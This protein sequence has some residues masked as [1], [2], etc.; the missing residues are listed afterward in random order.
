MRAR[1]ASTTSTGDNLLAAIS[2]A[3]TDAGRR[4]GSVAIRLT[5]FISLH[6]NEGQIDEPG[7]RRD[8]AL[9]PSDSSRG[10]EI[11]EDIEPGRLVQPLVRLAI[12][13]RNHFRIGALGDR[14]QGYLDAIGRVVPNAVP[15]R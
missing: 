13:F 15:R 5:S 6:A 8:E 11:V 14:L 1:S 2:C 4:E 3:R 9:E 12:G 10:I 7:L